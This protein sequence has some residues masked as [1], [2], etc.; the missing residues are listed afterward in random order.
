MAAAQTNAQLDELFFNI[1]QQCND[2]FFASAS[3]SRASHAT[4]T[5]T[6]LRNRAHTTHTFHA[7]SE[8]QRMGEPL[9]AS[10]LSAIESRAS[11][12]RA[13]NFRS[14]AGTVR[15]IADDQ[16]VAAAPPQLPLKAGSH[17][18]SL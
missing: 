5:E 4:G 3:G 6:S 9:R 1:R 18:V 12:N 14:S 17:I 7:E 11:T 13:A 2:P 8:R 10:A 15:D 16:E